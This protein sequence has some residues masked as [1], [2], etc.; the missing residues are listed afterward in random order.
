VKRSRNGRRS[1]TVR[2][3]IRDARRA[4]ASPQRQR[5]SRGRRGR[6]IS[7]RHFVALTGWCLDSSVQRCRNA[8]SGEL[9]S[10]RIRG[11][12]RPS[13][14]WVESLGEDRS[15]LGP[16]EVEALRDLAAE[17]GEQLDLSF[18]LDTLDDDVKSERVGYRHD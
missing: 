14:G 6:G 7:A 8:R 18:G 9:W 1:E 10:C 2:G 3:T 17:A 5:N 13:S 16:R 15:S 11:L 4:R 12:W